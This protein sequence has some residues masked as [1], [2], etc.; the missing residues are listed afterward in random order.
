M[1]AHKGDCDGTNLRERS[2]CRKGKSYP[3][4]D[5]LQH[6]NT[7]EGGLL[8]AVSSVLCFDFL[9]LWRSSH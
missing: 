3:F 8:V 4:G 6:K 5:V 1:N 9:P 2:P 7:L